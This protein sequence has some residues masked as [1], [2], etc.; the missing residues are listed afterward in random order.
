MM[1]P[2]LTSRISATGF[3][4]SCSTGRRLAGVGRV[5]G[6]GYQMLM[7]FLVIVIVFALLSLG[8]ILNNEV[9]MAGLQ[10]GVS[11]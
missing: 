4:R 9:G 1:Q 11:C 6:R 3:Q 7:K 8:W 10:L 2:E 5:S